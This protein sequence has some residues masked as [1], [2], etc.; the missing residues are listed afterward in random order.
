MKTR[1][2]LLEEAVQLILQHHKVALQWG[3]SVGK[4]KAAIT[5]LNELMK[6]DNKSF[7]VLLIVAETAHK[8]NW[9]EEIKKWKMHIHKL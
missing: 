4:S 1:E 8:N 7:N 9:K 5:M 3:T 2:S 6:R